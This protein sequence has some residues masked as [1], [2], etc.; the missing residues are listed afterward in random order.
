[1]LVQRINWLYPGHEA[2]AE[3][4][5][6]MLEKYPKSYDEIWVTTLSGFPPLQKHKECAEWFRNFSDEL[7]RRGIKVSLQLANSIGHGDMMGDEYDCS[8]LTDNPA[9]G[10]LVGED[11]VEAE[12]CF[13]W[14]NEAFREYTYREVALYAEIVKPDK[15]WIDDDL[16]PNN[17]LPVVNG[18]FCPDCIKNFNERHSVNFAR[19]ELVEKILGDELVWRERWI[20]FI[21]DGLKSFV[22]GLCEAVH[23]VSP[24]TEFGYQ[25]CDNGCYTGYGYGYIFD[26]MMAVNGKAPHYR[27]GGG[28]YD[29]HNLMSMLE[30]GMKL[31]YQHSFLSYHGVLSPEIECIPNT[32]YGKSTAAILLE[33]AH[34]LALGGHDMTYNVMDDFHDPFEWHEEKFRALEKMRPYFER[35]GEVSRRTRGD[36]LCFFVSKKSYNKP[37]EKGDTISKLN[38]EYHLSAY[39]LIRD[40]LPIV[41]DESEESVFLLHP[42]NAAI[43]A[44]NEV[45]SLKKRNVITCGESIA[46]LKKRG[47]DLGLTAIP[48]DEKNKGALREMYEP[49]ELCGNIS[50]RF[51]ENYYTKGRFEPHVLSDLPEG[52]TV[53]GRYKHNVRESEPINGSIATA[54][55]P[56]KEGGE[57]AVFS[58]SLWKT[59]KT[60]AERDRIL[61]VYDALANT[62]GARVLSPIQAT[63]HI[64]KDAQG[65]IHAVSLT[66]CSVGP[67]ENV[68]VFVK[69]P[70]GEKAVFWGQYAEKRELSVVHKEQGMVVTLPRIEPWSVA[71]VFFE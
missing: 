55:V 48:V 50:D 52:A 17:H 68:R 57:W 69:A 56:L 35:L 61:N 13:C 6:K 67:Q 33:T 15:F 27:A 12:Y 71:T 26:G 7:K 63:V 28:Y 66:N 11:G 39:N 20:E 47:F 34:Y 19:E 45:E 21:K 23:E 18:C 24:E 46:I 44:A 60:I 62:A 54:L 58:Y 64:R 43:M 14:N 29:E 3:F 25:S 70:F 53:L 40:G 51:C 65:R 9:V 49:H 10:K 1:M 31:A 42:D 36:G 30:K 38:Q 16:R 8:G 2:G 41:Y 5:L 37:L 32:A 22:G 59:V 4:Y